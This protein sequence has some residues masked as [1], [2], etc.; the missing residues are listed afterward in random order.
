M[1]D[2]YP[3]LCETKGGMI[4]FNPDKIYI[5]SNKHPDEWYTNITDIQEDALRRRVGDFTYYFDNVYKKEDIDKK[6]I[7]KRKYKI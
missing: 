5:C 3:M 1:L 2:K 4:Y 7:Y 6:W